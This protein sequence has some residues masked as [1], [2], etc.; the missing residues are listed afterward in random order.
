MFPA[1]K[2]RAINST[3]V[4]IPTSTPVQYKPICVTV[5]APS[6]IVISA[7]NA[8]PVM[9]P[10]KLLIALIWLTPSSLL[11]RLLI[12]TVLVHALQPTYYV[13]QYH[14][15]SHPLLLIP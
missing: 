5:G 6:A 7:E 12:V 10:K 15:V 11:L 13:R 8:A 9:I 3:I 14:F 1:M 4:N 2:E